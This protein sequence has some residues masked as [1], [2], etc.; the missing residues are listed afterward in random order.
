MAVK[1]NVVVCVS[2]YR[3]MLWVL[4]NVLDQESLA[5]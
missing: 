4:T 2:C 5:F 3:A 1:V